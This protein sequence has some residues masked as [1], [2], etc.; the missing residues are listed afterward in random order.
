MLSMEQGRGDEGIHGAW[1]K[2][3]RAALPKQKR[4]Y[5]GILPWLT[6]P[7]HHFL[8]KLKNAGRSGFV[9]LVSHKAS[10]NIFLKGC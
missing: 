2:D 9:A 3:S 5:S 10:V 4:W 8:D 7:S 6:L 1:R